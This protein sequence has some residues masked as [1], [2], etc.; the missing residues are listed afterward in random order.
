MMSEAL[1]LKTI[2]EGVETIEQLKILKNLGCHT[3][4]GYYLAKPMTADT[5]EDQFLKKGS[6][7]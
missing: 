3:I 5:L 4:Q 7:K 6:K 2:A 1:G